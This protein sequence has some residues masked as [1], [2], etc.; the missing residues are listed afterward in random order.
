MKIVNGLLNFVRL[1]CSDVFGLV[2]FNVV[3]SDV[4]VLFEH[5]FVVGSVKVW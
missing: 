4:L 5:Q 2:D 1:G 3:I